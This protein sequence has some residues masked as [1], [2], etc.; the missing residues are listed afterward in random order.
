MKSVKSR[1]FLILLISLGSIITLILTRYTTSTKTTSLTESTY[2]IMR[3]DI[4]LL[5]MRRAEKDFINRME[6]DDLGIFDRNY[7]AFEKD[8][9]AVVPNLQEQNIDH[10]LLLI[11]HNYVKEYKSLFDQIADKTTNIGLTH[12]LG[13][14][15]DLLENAHNTE[16]NLT[17]IHDTLLPKINA[18]KSHARM[19]ELTIQLSTAIIMLI[20]IMALVGALRNSFDSFIDFFN[21][22]K[23]GKALIPIQDLPYSEFKVMANI[24]NDTI[25][26]RF[27]AEDQLKDLN[28]NLE[29]RVKEAT[30]EIIDRNE[31]ITATHLH[32]SKLKSQ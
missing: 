27:K 17:A 3:L 4:R 30:K 1:L 8:W 5:N 15:A 18:A 28:N 16:N 25:S 22:A 26:A 14:M 23:T 11:L 32:S 24:A 13:L 9:N 6:A 21:N 2:L 31:E 12:K 20:V 10:Q 29:Q 7:D 19:Q